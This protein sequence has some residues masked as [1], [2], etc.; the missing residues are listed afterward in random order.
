M[1]D[2]LPRDLTFSQ[3]MGLSPVR[4]A[5]QIGSMDEELRN[6]AVCDGGPGRCGTRVKP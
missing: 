4:K 1:P 2:E 6:G 5:L 3:R